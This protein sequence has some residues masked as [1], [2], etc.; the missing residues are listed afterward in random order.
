MQLVINP[1]MLLTPK[2]SL[3][4]L[5][6]SNTARQGVEKIRSTGYTAIPVVDGRTGLYVGTVS[7]GD[8]LWKLL[9]SP[10]Q[11]LYDLEKVKL[12]DV[13]DSRKY[14][15]ANVETTMDELVQLIMLQ[16]FVPIVD[17]RGVFMGIV[18]RRRVIEYYDMTI[19]SQN[20]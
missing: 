13:I 9:D 3:K 14:K 18:T 17:D 1:L 20:G 5:D 7:E 16:N 6:A 8:F 15:A 10:G 19:K 11:S 4:F 2:A 12:I